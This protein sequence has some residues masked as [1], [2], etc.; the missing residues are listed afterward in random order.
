V[1]HEQ[2]IGT[3]SRVSDVEISIVDD[4]PHLSDK[5]SSISSWQMGYIFL[6]LFEE[7]LVM[8]NIQ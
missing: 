8:I 5:P 6:K 3:D 1:R 7:H 4:A 2:K